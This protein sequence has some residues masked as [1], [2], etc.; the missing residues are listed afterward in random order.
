MQE[1]ENLS[2]LEHLPVL[3]ALERLRYMERQARYMY[4]FNPKTAGKLQ[5]EIQQKLAYY[6]EEA[7]KLS[8]QP[9]N[10]PAGLGA[11]AHSVSA[12]ITMGLPSAQNLELAKRKSA[13][14]EAKLSRY[15]AAPIQL[16]NQSQLNLFE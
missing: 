9:E 13:R 12:Y 6:E 2:I 4:Q 11:S 3:E 5:E 16:P 1:F 14:L 8:P 15:L 10:E 7:R